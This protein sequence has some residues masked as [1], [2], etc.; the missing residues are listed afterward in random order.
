MLAATVGKGMTDVGKL[1]TYFSN[2]KNM[3]GKFTYKRSWSVS[4]TG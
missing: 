3:K 2:A 1:Q 4:N